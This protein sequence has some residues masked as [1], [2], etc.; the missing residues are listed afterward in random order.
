MLVAIEFDHIEKKNTYWRFRCDCGNEKLISIGH[1]RSGHTKSCGCIQK[2]IGANKTHGE[3]RTRLY[4]IWGKMKDR[5]YN[6]HNSAFHR[7]GG[8]GIRLCGEW[9]KSFETFKEWAMSAGY[10]DN[11]TID[12]IDNDGNYSPKNCRWA[13]LA[14]QQRN[15]CDVTLIKYDGD[16]L[17]IQELADKIGVSYYLIWSRVRTGEMASMVG[18]ENVIEREKTSYGNIIDGCAVGN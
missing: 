16:L 5:C 9:E 6:P 17:T 8:R 11:L 3:S 10:E 1:V 2:G 12:R 14:E 13:T 15:R 18:A 7:Y 4:R